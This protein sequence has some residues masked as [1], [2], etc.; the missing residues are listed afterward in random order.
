[1]SSD[2]ATT[3]KR[4]STRDETQK[5]LLDAAE[6]LFAEYGF[7]A[8]PVRAIIKLAETRLA[9]INDLF[10]GKEELFK[11]VI[12][13]RANVINED[14]A[15]RL[16]LVPIKG[17]AKVRLQAVVEAFAEPLLIRSK[18]GAG[19][20]NYLRLIAQLNTMGSDVLLPL[21]DQ[22]NPMAARFIAQIADIFP[23]MTQRQQLIAFQ[24]MMSATLALFSNNRRIDALSDNIIKSSNF[25][26]H[27]DDLLAFITSGIVGISE[28]KG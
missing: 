8:V 17:K 3:R 28:T 20:E 12:A 2:N 18:E 13:R 15:I 21:A 16:A 25:D 11:E 22:F 24:L 14:R 9:D 7:H 1:M 6:F 19:W 4:R 26:Q 10:G 23:A 5:R 27:Y